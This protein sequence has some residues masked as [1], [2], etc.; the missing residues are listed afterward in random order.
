MF[1]GIKVKRLSIL[2]TE[3]KYE[4]Q[5]ESGRPDEKDYYVV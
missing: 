3:R 5:T 1:D 2:P 4:T